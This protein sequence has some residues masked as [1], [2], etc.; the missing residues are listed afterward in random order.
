MVL[1]IST[2][3]ISVSEHYCGEEVIN[4]SL[5]PVEKPCC[6]TPSE[7]CHN[8]YIF[9]QLKADFTKSSEV[10]QLNI[11]ELHHADF[12]ALIILLHEFADNNPIHYTNEFY[13]PDQHSILLENQSFL[14]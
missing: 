10:V 1:L 5:N 7:C 3:G 8:E 2:M 11:S 13:I 12:P 14:L 9:L 6:E 4:I